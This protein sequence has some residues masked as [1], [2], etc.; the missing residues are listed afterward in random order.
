MTGIG[1][2]ENRLADTNNGHI[3]RKIQSEK[4]CNFSILQKVNIAIVGLD[5]K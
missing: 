5:D 1:V 2:S 4:R 3:N